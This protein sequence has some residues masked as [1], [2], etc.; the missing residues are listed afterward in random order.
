[1]VYDFTGIG[2]NEATTRLSPQEDIQFENK[3]HHTPNKT[4]NADRSLGPVYIRMSDLVDTYMRLWFCMDNLPLHVLPCPKE[5][6]HQLPT[7]PLPRIH[8]HGIYM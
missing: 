1:M 2:L 8:T 6:T 4:L 3:L 7:G 5:D